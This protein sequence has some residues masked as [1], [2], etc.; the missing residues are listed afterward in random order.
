MVQHQS[1]SQ[2]AGERE[3]ED[4]GL[5]AR[6]TSLNRELTES[7]GHNFLSFFWLSC[8]KQ[9]RSLIL[10]DVDGLFSLKTSSAFEVRRARGLCTL[11]G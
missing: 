11:V 9:W 8:E 5:A 4:L 10:L 2:G 1:P 3:H 7:P 6:Q